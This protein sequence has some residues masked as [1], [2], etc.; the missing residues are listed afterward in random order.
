ETEWPECALWVVVRDSG[1]E[2]H[3]TDGKGQ[4]QRI[5]GLF[6]SGNPMVVQGQYLDDAKQPTKMYYAFYGL[7]PHEVGP[8]GRFAA[9]SV[10]P[11]QCGVQEKP[12]AEIRPYPGISPECRPSSMDAIRSAA[13]ASRGNQTAEWRWLRAESR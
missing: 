2:I 9:A 6:A 3:M 13:T 5:G 8:G 1:T 7:E 4:S 10:W 11:V 12:G